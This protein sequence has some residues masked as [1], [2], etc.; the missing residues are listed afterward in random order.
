M[1]VWEHGHGRG[2]HGEDV[3]RQDG[4]KIL[5]FGR[6]QGQHASQWEAVASLSGIFLCSK[7]QHDREIHKKV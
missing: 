1:V 5:G 3:G 2:A 7:R 4:D 6:N